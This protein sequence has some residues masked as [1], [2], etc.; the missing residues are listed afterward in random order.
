VL[1]ALLA[2]GYLITFRIRKITE[3]AKLIPRTIICSSTDLIKQT[4]V[5][6][7]KAVML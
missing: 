4:Q 5:V 7:R 2:C 3:M 6:G 1:D